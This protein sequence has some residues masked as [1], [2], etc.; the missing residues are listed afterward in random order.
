M[1]DFSNFNSL[2][3]EQIDEGSKVEYYII[4]GVF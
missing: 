3:V 4:L 1:D 2:F